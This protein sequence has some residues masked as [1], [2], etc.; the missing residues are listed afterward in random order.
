[1]KKKMQH[2]S[3]GIGQLGLY[4]IMELLPGM[5]SIIRKELWIYTG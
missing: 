1:M 4:F 2:L 5:Y 3:E